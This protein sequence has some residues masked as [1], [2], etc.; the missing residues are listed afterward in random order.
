LNAIVAGSLAAIVTT[1][2][3]LAGFTIASTVPAGVIVPS[4]TVKV[5]VVS[6][7]ASSTIGIVIVSCVTA[8]P[9]DSETAGG[10]TSKATAVPYVS[11][12]ATLMAPVPPE[13]TTVST[14]FAP[15]VADTPAMLLKARVAVSLPRMVT[16]TTLLPLPRMAPRLP[17]ELIVP[18]FMVNVSAIS[19]TA[20]SL[21]AMLR[22]TVAAESPKAIVVGGVSRSLPSAVVYPIVTAMS[23][24]PLP[25]VRVTVKETL[26]PSAMLT[27]V[28]L[29]KEMVAVSLALMVM[30][31]IL[32]AALKRPQKD[33]PAVGEVNAMVNASSPSEMVSSV[34]GI[35]T[36]A[37]VCPLIKDTDV[38][39]V[40]AS[41]EPPSAG[42]KV[43][44]T[45]A[46]A[47][48]VVTP[49]L[50]IVRVADPTFSATEMETG[51]NSRYTLSRIVTVTTED[52]SIKQKLPENV[53]VSNVTRITSPGSTTLSPRRV[54]ANVS[55]ADTPFAY[56]SGI[57]KSVKSVPGVAVLEGDSNA[58]KPAQA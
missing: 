28:M 44:D 9:I 4:D 43:K 31:A 11:V 10:V 56:D 32:D 55:V 25:P 41:A 33:P 20:S 15:S 50:V 7:M 35:V 17:E 48:V 47:V 27:E 2:A 5:S 46:A 53:L 3:E 6:A 16:A 49:L 26:P 58:L 12:T 18:R 8:A 36:V 51:E 39:S 40:P 45:D 54:M 38:G 57:E 13:R 52:E 29:V 19:A 22:A 30:V 24:A 1:T 23:Y 37:R 14:V 21:V 42:A 34:I